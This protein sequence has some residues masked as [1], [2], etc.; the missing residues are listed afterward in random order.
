M[1]ILQSISKFVKD[2]PPEHAFEISEAGIS[3]VHGSHTGFER[4][5]PGTI[6]VSPSADNVIRPE[7][8]ASMIGHIAPANG[9][10]KRRGAALILPDYSARVTVLDFDSF[11]TVPAE[12]L[13]L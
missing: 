9:N 10:R 13:S 5:E 4:F 2:P 12:Q 7:V 3:Y 11:P 6:V 1:S 8:V